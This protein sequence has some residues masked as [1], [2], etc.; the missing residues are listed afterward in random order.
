MFNAKLKTYKV[1]IKQS[2]S[3]TINLEIDNSQSFEPSFD[4]SMSREIEKEEE[5]K[6]SIDI[7]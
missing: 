4:N 2:L 6:V 1:Y 3:Q 5:V 7:S